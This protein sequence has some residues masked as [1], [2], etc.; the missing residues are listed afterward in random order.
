MTDLNTLSLDALYDELARSGLVHRLIEL[1]RDE[2]LGPIPATGDI[3]TL[4]CIPDGTIGNATVVARTRGVIA[5]LAAVDDMLAVMAPGVAFSASVGDGVTVEA[6]TV[7]GTLTGPLR[8]I[9]TV[10]RTLLNML[11]RLSGIATRTAAF[12]GAIAGTGAVVLDTRKTTPGLRM[13][14]KYAVRCGGGMCHRIGLYDAVLVK[15]NHIAGVSGEALAGVIAAAASQARSM[16]SESVSA[17]DEQLRFVE[18][19]VDTLG[20]LE[21]VLGLE[22]GLVDIVLL[23]NMSPQ[24]LTRA[25]QIRDRLLGGVLL[26]ASGGVTL[27]TIGEIARTG[28]DRISVGSLTHGATWLDVALDMDRPD[29]AG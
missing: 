27:D 23:D 16:R 1:A 13:L 11:G 28:V 17:Q 26:E 5:G 4:A 7:L 14:E 8:Q 15:D 18:V 21:A 25:V 19:E 9:L 12:V 29:D 2:D 22:P 24:R 6:E 3:T 10:E 20:Q